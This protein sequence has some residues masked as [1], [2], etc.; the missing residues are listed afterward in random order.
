MDTFQCPNEGFL[1]KI[2]SI[3]DWHLRKTNTFARPRVSV[4]MS[5]YFK[6]ILFLFLSWPP[7]TLQIYS[8]IHSA[9]IRNVIF[10]NFD[11]LNA[12]D[13]SFEAWQ[14][15]EFQQCYYYFEVSGGTNFQLIVITSLCSGVAVWW[16]WCSIS[17]PLSQ[18]SRHDHSR[19]GLVLPILQSGK[20]ETKYRKIP[21]IS[22]WLVAIRK[23]IRRR[24]IVGGLKFRRT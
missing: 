2:T 13:C 22:P 24:L 18:T 7:E 8:Q 3:K 17:H 6:T 5:F 12:H 16:L 1:L 14:R 11:C 19:W 9:Q 4:L 20:M 10:E 23:H 21:N 15:T